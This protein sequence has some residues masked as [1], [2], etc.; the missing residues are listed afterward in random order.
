MDIPKLRHPELVE[1]SAF[2]GFSQL[3]RRFLSPGT[4]PHRSIQGK[5]ILRQAQ[6]DR[7]LFNGSAQPHSAATVLLNKL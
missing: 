3:K 7:R 4:P 5:L 1:G 2:K 6:D